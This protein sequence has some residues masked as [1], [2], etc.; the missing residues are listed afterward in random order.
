MEA[1]VNR[2]GRKRH[3]VSL[4]YKKRKEKG[5]E[6]KKRKSAIIIKTQ[7]AIERFKAVSPLA[8]MLL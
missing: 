4:I 5:K 1:E 2:Y 6:K 3:E 8:G 7:T